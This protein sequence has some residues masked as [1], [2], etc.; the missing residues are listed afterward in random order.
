MLKMFGGKIA[1]ESFTYAAKGTK[2]GINNLT[3][4]REVMTIFIP[5]LFRILFFV[6]LNG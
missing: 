5:V 3:E 4:R 1:L 2:H 6:I